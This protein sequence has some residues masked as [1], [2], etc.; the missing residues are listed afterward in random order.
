MPDK[1]LTAFQPAINPMIQQ[2]TTEFLSFL[3]NH[4]EKD[5]KDTPY[6][7]LIDGCFQG[8]TVVQ[9]ICHN[10]GKKKQRDEPFYYYQVGVKERNNLGEALEHNSQGEVINDWMCEFCNQKSDIT[11]KTLLKETPNVMF[12]HLQRI[13]FDFDRYMN[14][15]IHTHLEFPEQLNIEPFIQEGIELR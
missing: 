15:K 4:I 2:D 1:L 7:H 11:K 12:I 10:C 3:F 13:V 6:R 8:T 9:M 5:L 14:T